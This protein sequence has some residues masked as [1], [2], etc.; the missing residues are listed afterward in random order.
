MTENLNQTQKYDLV[1]GTSE[2]DL[3]GAAILGGLESVKI[4]LAGTVLKEKLSKANYP[5]ALELH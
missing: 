3:T 4:R 1:L 2:P 5:Q